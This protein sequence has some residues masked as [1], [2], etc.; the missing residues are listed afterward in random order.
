MSDKSQQCACHLKLI[1][2]QERPSLNA[3]CHCFGVGRSL[4]QTCTMIRRIRRMP[5]SGSNSLPSATT[6]P[7]LAGD[8]GH[9]HPA[10]AQCLKFCLPLLRRFLGVYGIYGVWVC[11]SQCGCISK[12]RNTHKLK[13]TLRAGHAGVAASNA[14]MLRAR[15]TSSQGPAQGSHRRETEGRGAREPNVQETARV[16]STSG[17]ERRLIHGG[18]H[19]IFNKGGC[20][21]IEIGGRQRRGRGPAK[22]AKREAEE[23][24]EEKVAQGTNEQGAL[25][26]ACGCHKIIRGSRR[27]KTWNP[28]A[29]RAEDTCLHWNL[30]PIR[31][32]GPDRF[33][34][35]FK[36]VS[37]IVG[38]RK[39]V[40]SRNGAPEQ[41]GM[42]LFGS[43]TSKEPK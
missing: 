30:K 17:F 28:S 14:D 18:N 11:Q 35:N 20:S 12:L 31:H 40:L 34:P 24:A 29:M 5:P 38:R 6:G 1:I 23:A 25:S 43:R 37:P 2:Q 42:S 10:S 22:Q 13:P 21:I 41:P 4:A 15:C 3:C 27:S 36:G 7:M 33:P 8:L 9:H 32:D 16:S 19:A 39:R 26:P